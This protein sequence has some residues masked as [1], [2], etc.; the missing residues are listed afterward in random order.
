MSGKSGEHK[1]SHSDG[2]EIALP[3]LKV[4]QKAKIS[5]VHTRDKGALR[6]LISMGV[7][8]HADIVLTQKFPAYVFRRGHSVF[9][10]D[11]ELASLI[12]VKKI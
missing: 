3:D 1:A 6:K 10:I 7:L 12:F 2:A 5:K 8:P 11:R 9:S 4:N